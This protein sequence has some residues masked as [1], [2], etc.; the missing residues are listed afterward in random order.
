MGNNEHILNEKGD[1][2]MEMVKSGYTPLDVGF[3]LAHGQA[4]SSQEILSD[5]TPVDW[6]EDVLSGKDKGKT[7]IKSKGEEDELKSAILLLSKSA[8]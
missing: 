8:K 5:I 4:V 2:N 6:S 7:I 1:E 3:I